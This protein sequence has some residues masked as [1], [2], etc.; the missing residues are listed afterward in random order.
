MRAGADAAVVFVS[1]R[2]R[3]C[4]R[5]RTVQL[6]RILETRHQD[7]GTN[8]SWFRMLQAGC[9]AN[10]TWILFKFVVKRLG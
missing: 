5:I 7:P 2:R 1:V 9:T 4:G 10:A 8:V 6:K 3:S